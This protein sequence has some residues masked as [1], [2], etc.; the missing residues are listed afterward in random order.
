M[1][2]G[3]TY[4]YAI[5]FTIGTGPNV[6]SYADRYA[7]F[8]EQVRKTG[9]WTETTSFALTTTNATIDLLAARLYF[10]SK[11]DATADLMVVFDNGRG[12]AYT[13]GNAEYQKPLSSN[14]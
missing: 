13:P 10:Q 5:S 9:A 3:M 4:K 6:F 2:N 8:M 12:V 7:S 14:T 1:V 11:F